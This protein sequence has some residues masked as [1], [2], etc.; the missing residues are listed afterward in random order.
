[1]ETMAELGLSLSQA[2]LARNISLEE[3]ERSTR[4]SRRF[5][6][7]LEEHDYSVFPA[8]VYARGF[9]RTYCRFLDIDPDPQLR[10]LPL[11]W[12]Q[13]AESQ[14]P[15]PDIRRPV[16]LNTNWLLG[17]VAIVFLAVAAVL[18]AL[19]RDDVSDLQ[20]Q[21]LT[22][23]ADQQSGGNQASALESTPAG[24]VPNFVGTTASDAQSFMSSRQLNYILV[25]T[26]DASAPVGVVISQ[27]PNAGSRADTSSVVTLTVSARPATNVMRTDC[28]VLRGSNTRTAAEQNWFQNN[29]QQVAAP[30]APA[31]TPPPPAGLA[32]RTSC[33]E[34]RGTQYRSDN[35]MNFFRAN[36]IN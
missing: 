25:E 30:P 22:A 26:V 2:R 28:T 21:L 14:P 17:G 6:L 31:A 4:I 5:L 36:C 27:T 24:V 23:P 1:M 29:C 35:E 3:A 33:A 34:I 20:G 9:L 7:A 32:D 10:E 11:A 16:E 19:N 15:L 13:E 18:I 12:S 8:P